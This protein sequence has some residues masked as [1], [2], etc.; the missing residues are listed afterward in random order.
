MAK[1]G[2]KAGRAQGPVAGRDIF[3]LVGDATVASC[4]LPAPTRNAA[5]PVRRSAPGTVREPLYLVQQETRAEV[6]ILIYPV[7]AAIVEAFP[8]CPTAPTVL[9]NRVGRPLGK[10]GQI[11]DRLE[12]A[13]LVLSHYAEVQIE[14]KRAAEY[15]FHDLRKLARG[16]A[17]RRNTIRLGQARPDQRLEA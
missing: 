10:P 1:A 5:L 17:S 4:R 8:A 2:R 15:Q 6:F 9:Y 7:L 14:V 12:K 13:M 11:E 3:G 16:T